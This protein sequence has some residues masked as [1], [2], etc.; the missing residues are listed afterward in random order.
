MAA[1][2]KGEGAEAKSKLSR[3]LETEVELE[4]MLEEARQ[5]AKR[6]VELAE[7]A[8]EDRVQEFELQLEAEE[9][10]VRDRIAR[11]R[12]QAIAAIREEARRETDQ[13]DQI[14]DAT[15]SE[16]ASYVL[17]LLLGRPGS[18]GSD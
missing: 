4:S 18:R 16:L 12:D 5:E 1:K 11:E 3:L 2:L 13:L 17:D 14:D 9:T 7:A 6:L 8:A 15:V 10:L